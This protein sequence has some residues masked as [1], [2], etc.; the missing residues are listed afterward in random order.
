MERE[1]EAWEWEYRSVNGTFLPRLPAPSLASISSPAAAI[2][3]ADRSL[4]GLVQR[5][6][7]I[8]G[9]EGET[10]GVF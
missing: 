7:A 4:V 5:L 9:M 10:M 3:S 2:S 6:S 1:D 8:A